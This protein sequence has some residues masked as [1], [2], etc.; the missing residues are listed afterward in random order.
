MVNDAGAPSSEVVDELLG[1]YSNEERQQGH[2]EGRGTPSGERFRRENHLGQGGG[3]RLATRG[4]IAQ[5]PESPEAVD[6]TQQG[7]RCTPCDESSPSLNFCRYV[8][9]R[10][11]IRALHL[12]RVI[13]VGKCLLLLHR[14]R[15]EITFSGV[16]GDEIPFTSTFRFCYM[17]RWNQ[18]FATETRRRQRKPKQPNSPHHL[19]A[20]EPAHRALTGNV[21]AHAPERLGEGAHH[22]VHVLRVHAAVLARAPPRLAQRSDAVGLV[23]VHISL[24]ENIEHK[25]TNT[26][27]T[28]KS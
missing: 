2:G 7:R 3:F 12:P 15:H 6:F 16:H 22:H 25:N 9:T 8:G 28:Q 4:R 13:Y 26:Q 5:K 23:K 17:R 14:C 10:E 18:P 1:T 11:G 24:A 20:R 19:T 27:I 21:A